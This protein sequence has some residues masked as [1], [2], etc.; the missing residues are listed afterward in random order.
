MFIYNIVKVKVL[1][2]FSRGL[3]MRQWRHCQC[4]LHASYL[5]VNFN[6]SLKVAM[7]SFLCLRLGPSS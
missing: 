5:P 4:I 6:F 7:L 1:P 3:K 2:T